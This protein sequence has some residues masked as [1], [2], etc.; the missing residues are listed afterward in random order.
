MLQRFKMPDAEYF[1]LPYASNSTLKDAHKMFT[2]SD[3]GVWEPTKAYEFG[4]A[5]DAL[6]TSPGILD[7]SMI[8]N[9]DRRLLPSMRATLEND[10][11][12]FKPLLMNAST[13]VVFVETEFVIYLD[14]RPITFPAKCKYDFWIDKFDFGADLK[15]VI[16]KDQHAFEAAC[17]HFKYYMQGALYMDITKSDRFILVGISKRNFKIFIIQIRRDDARYKIGK[18]QYEAC[19]GPWWKLYGFKHFTGKNQ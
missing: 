19:F 10:D 9:E 18:R 7:T 12:V 1:A 11:K 16:C 8:S 6:L 14:G 15:A 2:A 5:F 13:Q 4:S 3:T 17:E